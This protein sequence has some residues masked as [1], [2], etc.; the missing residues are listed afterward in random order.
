MVLNQVEKGRVVFREAA[1]VL[2]RSEGK[3]WGYWQPIERRGL[4]D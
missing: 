1:K 4:E 3:V 2:G